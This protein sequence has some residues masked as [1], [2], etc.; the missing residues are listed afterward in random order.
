MVAHALAKAGIRN[1]YGVIGIP[2]TE[3]ASAAQVCTIMTPTYVCQAHKR[4][5]PFSLTL[6]CNRG[7]LHLLKPAYTDQLHLEAHRI[8]EFWPVNQLSCRP[9][10]RH[11][12]LGCRLLASGILASAMSKL[13]VMRQLPP[14]S[15]QEFQQSYSQFQGQEQCMALPACHMPKLIHGPSYSYL[16][17]QNRCGLQAN[18]YCNP[19][20]RICRQQCHLWQ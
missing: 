8:M 20:S 19:L 15:S 18:P 5:P 2:V 9:S 13:L 4:R 16:D 11:S 12:G 3:L 17:L 7:K 14:A 6:F 10:L 1:I